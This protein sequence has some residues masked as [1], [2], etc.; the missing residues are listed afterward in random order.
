MAGKLAIVAG[1]DSNNESE[2]G[3]PELSKWLHDRATQLI[4][5][6]LADL[7]PKVGGAGS[8]GGVKAI[9]CRSPDEPA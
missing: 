9:E 4:M 7:T 2:F 8:S 5:K 6:N 1:S 3:C